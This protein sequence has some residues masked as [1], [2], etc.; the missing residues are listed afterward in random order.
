ML[1]GGGCDDGRLDG[2]GNGGMGLGPARSCQPL[3]ADEHSPLW[4]SRLPLASSRTV[5]AAVVDVI[6]ATLAAGQKRVA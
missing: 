4:L 6:M 3:G 1:G 2:G 5:L